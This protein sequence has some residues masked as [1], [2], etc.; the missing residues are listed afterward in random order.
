MSLPVTVYILDALC[1]VI[2]SKIEV[3]KS[4][5]HETTIEMIQTVIWFEDNG[6]LELGKCIIDLVEHH[7]AIAPVRV[8]LCLLIIKPDSSA[9]IIHCLL[10]VPDCHEGIATI[11]MVL[12]MDGALITGGCTLQACDGLTEFL[13]GCFSILL[14]LLLVELVQQG[15]TIVVEL[16]GQF[17][18]LD[19]LFEI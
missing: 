6:L 5:M 11:C 17:L 19:L 16:M 3:H 2:N 1:E 9:E 4:G 13:D 12:S 8:V 14:L 7:H 10:V 18:F 15:F